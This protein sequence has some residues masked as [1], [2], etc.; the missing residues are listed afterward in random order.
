MARIRTIKPEFFTSGDVVELS[1][2]ARLFYIGLWC[3]AD[4][5][6]RMSWSVKTLKLRY[7]PGDNCNVDELADELVKS[8]MLTLYAI[9]GKQ[10]AEIP[11]FKKHQVINNRES[12]STIPAPT[13]D[14]CTTRESGVKAE[15]RKGRKG[16][17]GKG[18]EGVDATNDASEPT[19]SPKG[20]RLE[21]D[22]ILPKAWGEWAM[23]EQPTWSADHC[24]QIGVKFG[25]FWQSKT[26]KDATK[27]DWFKTWQVWVLNDGPMKAAPGQS[28]GTQGSPLISPAIAQTQALIASQ[29]L[30][31]EEIEANKAR[32]AAIRAAMPNLKVVA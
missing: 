32:A 31:P 19:R 13:V 14:A 11:S 1:P 5:E 30:S 20:S 9:E 6:G 8:G 27:L 24:R 25:A 4:K 17:E 26:G 28:T 29:S 23:K 2:L 7:L 15:G 10:Y 21:S 16:K 18:R 22:W 12:E 3:E